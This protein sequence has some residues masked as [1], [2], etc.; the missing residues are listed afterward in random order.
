MLKVSA[1]LW[2]LITAI[3]LMAAPQS[4]LQNL[5]ITTEPAEIMG[6][7]QLDYSP[8]PYLF[9]SLPFEKE[10]YYSLEGTITVDSNL[11]DPSLYI[12]STTYPVVISING[13]RIYQWGD[14]HKSQHLADYRSHAIGI[15]ERYRGEHKFRID[16]WFN[17]EHFALPELKISERGEM[18]N[19]A[20]L[21][22]FFN[23]HLLNGILIAA[24]F[25]ALLFSGYFLISGMKEQE[26]LYFALFSIA[27]VCS[28]IIF[29]LNSQ[30]FPEIPIFKFARVATLFLP[31]FM[32]QF[33][34]TYT[35]VWDR[36]RLLFWIPLGASLLISVLIAFADKGKVGINRVFNGAGSILLMVEF[37]MVLVILIRAF[38]TTRKGEV[39]LIFT[40]F[41]AFI[42]LV[43]HDLY[44][45]R[46]GILP[47]FWTV[48]YGY[49]IVSV[50]M[51][52]ALILRQRKAYEDLLYLRVELLEANRKVA[53]E[54]ENRELFIQTIAH[55]LRTPL[56]GMDGGLRS[57]RDRIQE[58]PYQELLEETGVPTSFHRLKITLSNI[59]G[60]VAAEHGTL[61]IVSHT[62]NISEL[63]DELSQH[64]NTLADEKGITF[65]MLYGT[66]DMPKNYRGD[67][68]H[69]QLV[70]ANIMFN[71]VK[72]TYSGGVTCKVNYHNEKLICSIADTGCGFPS[73]KKEALLASFHRGEEISFSQRYEG[74]GLG[75][76]ITD[77]VVKAMGGEMSLQSTP[78]QGTTV[79][80]TVPLIAEYEKEVKDL[81][82]FTILVV[83]DNRINCQ[84]LSIMVTK[85]GCEAAVAY[86]GEEAVYLQ[87][88]HKYDLIL[89]DI[90]MP[91]MDGF[92]ATKNIREFDG[93]TPIVAVTAN[94]EYHACIAAGMN[95]HLAKPV[96]YDHL[97]E[98]LTGF[99]Q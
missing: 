6:Q 28:L 14:G 95:E 60:F 21:I 69:I 26:I 98:I 22:S 76:S 1:A 33:V 23:I 54:A 67:R 52:G 19:R 63:L 53:L 89:M 85:M 93:D 90:Q 9:T 41:L 39:A 58:T 92:T 79:I 96:N 12:G 38:Y 59:F 84:L 49:L 17:G 2:V 36:S 68:D 57:L 99:L 35:V 29:P 75:L 77:S 88:K 42:V 15:S 13:E 40:G 55:E 91:V 31:F 43:I 73:E 37:G 51:L 18:Q 80:I 30:Q 4:S 87:R 7:D 10:G 50:S 20:T 34:R 8:E 16:F 11:L 56:H 5:K 66:K 86:N 94:A 71:A 70:L 24:V 64:F 46:I 3:A 97:Q 44:F 65:S 62:F 72:Y 74:V 48:S 45:L 83:D 82:A 78:N 32:M 47:L 61:R 25:T 27:L 81:S